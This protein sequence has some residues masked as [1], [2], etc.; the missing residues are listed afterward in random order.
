[1]FPR[2]K[3]YPE[4]TIPSLI[5]YNK[6][7]KKIKRDPLKQ[8][9]D[10]FSC[11]IYCYLAS[12]PNIN[13]KTFMNL[14]KEAPI[15]RIGF[16]I[17]EYFK[18]HT[19]K[20]DFIELFN[21]LTKDDSDYPICFGNCCSKIL[22]KTDDS[23]ITNLIFEYIDK[24]LNSKYYYKGLKKESAIPNV[25]YFLNE[26][27]T[28][29]G[30]SEKYNTYFKNYKK[31][32]LEKK[33]SEEEFLYETL[34]S[35]RDFKIKTLETYFEKV[36]KIECD[37]TRAASYREILKSKNCTSDLRDRILKEKKNI[38]RKIFVNY[39]YSGLCKNPNIHLNYDIIY[40]FVSKRISKTEDQYEVILDCLKNKNITV[41]MSEK[42]VNLLLE[43]DWSQIFYPT[44]RYVPIILANT[45]TFILSD[46][47][48]SYELKEK[49][50]KTYL[51]LHDTLNMIYPSDG[52]FKNMVCTNDQI[53]DLFKRITKITKNHRLKYMILADFHNNDIL[54]FDLRKE[55][56]D[57]LIKAFFSKDMLLD[58][59]ENTKMKKKYFGFNEGILSESEKEFIFRMLITSNLVK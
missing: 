45:F 10:Y 38:K 37:S 21:Y 6:S 49:I 15:Y 7:L 11:T 1:M 47:K 8:P 40:K 43:R 20:K 32:F 34:C 30:N 19:T 59:R 39:L 4:L 57:K 14:L 44:R 16:M 48:I 22:S 54:S 56:Q 41:E 55:I 5:K 52:L 12:N 53:K 58:L 28:N 35:N 17:E 46:K 25:Y 24:N 3:K 9:W 27:I 13:R 26:Y 50:V 29:H 2:F 42:L 36:K 51:H 31:F 18:N 23:E 33:D